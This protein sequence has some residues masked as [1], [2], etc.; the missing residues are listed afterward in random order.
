MKFASGILPYSP[1]ERDADLKPRRKA[2]ERGV[3]RRKACPS[4]QRYDIE[5]TEESRELDRRRLGE[6]ESA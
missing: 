1:A 6:P 3:I 2:V 4:G 5:G